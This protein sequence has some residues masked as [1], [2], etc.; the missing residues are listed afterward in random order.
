M[1][2]K[3]EV[4]GSNTHPVYKFL[5]TCF[6]GDIAWNFRGKFLVN[7]AGVPIARF[8]EKESWENI[9]KIIAEEL[10]RDSKL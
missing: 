2:S 9:E 4:N 1:F 8:E 3:V 10:A 7:R 5:K 6:P